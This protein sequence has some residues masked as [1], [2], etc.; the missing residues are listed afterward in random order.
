MS[1]EPPATVFRVGAARRGWRLDRFLKERIPQLSRQAIQ[2]AIRVRVGL[3][4]LADPRPATRLHPGDDVIV[5]YPEIREDAEEL[6][7]LQVPVL[8]EDEDLLAVDKPAGMVVHPTNRVRRASLISILRE[9]HPVGRRLTLA[10]RLD[11]ETSGVLLLAKGA[12]AARALH[13]AFDARQVEKRYLAVVAGQMEP[14]AGVLEFPLSRARRGR[15]WIKQQV[16]RENGARAVTPYRVVRQVPGGTLV[17]LR[18]VTGRQHQIRVHLHAVG[19]PVVG[20]KLYGPDERSTLELLGSGLGPEALRRLGAP[21]QLLHAAALLLDHPLTGVP[22]A[23][24]SP[25]PDDM[26]AWLADAAA[27]TAAPVEGVQAGR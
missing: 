19:H 10:H 12:A 20:D 24:R 26:R 14:A 27:R 15:V 9:R 11:R 17:D 5:G 22:L 2:R 7:R 6:A 18:P 25:L 4:R 13:R 21:R 23:I 3:A 1:P 8:Y 16:D